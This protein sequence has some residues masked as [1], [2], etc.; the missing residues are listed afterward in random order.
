MRCH[1]DDRG[2]SAAH[3]SRTTDAMNE[4]GRVLRRIKPVTKHTNAHT[5]THEN[6]VKQTTTRYRK[7]KHSCNRNVLDNPVNGW[8]VQA[9]CSHIR[10]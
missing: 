1:K 4:R 9:A 7:R 2:T 10:R 3:A 5:E 6:E 8:D